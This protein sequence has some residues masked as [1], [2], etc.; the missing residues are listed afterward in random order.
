MEEENKMNKLI[1]S[2]V[3]NVFSFLCHVRWIQS[4]AAIMARERKK[5]KKRVIVQCKHNDMRKTEVYFVFH[6]VTITSVVHSE[7]D[8]LI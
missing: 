8:K 6:V 3:V 7:W 5:E 4:A 1:L 2:N